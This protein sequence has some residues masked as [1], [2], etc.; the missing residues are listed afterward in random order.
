[1][2]MMT[3]THDDLKAMISEAVN[4]TLSARMIVAENASRDSMTFKF[5]MHKIAEKSWALKNWAVKKQAT[6]G[7]LETA[8]KKHTDYGTNGLVRN[9]LDKK[10]KEAHKYPWDLAI[11]FDRME[12][13]EQDAEVEKYLKA[14][15]DEMLD[16]TLSDAVSTLKEKYAGKEPAEMSFDE[17]CSAIREINDVMDKF[18]AYEPGKKEIFEE[19]GIFDLKKRFMSEWKARR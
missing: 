18:G 11:E 15:D 5:V 8:F 10:S 3:L 14:Q 1:M 7:A 2:A 12:P 17:I 16:D 19:F 4:R 13:D 9:Y 6:L